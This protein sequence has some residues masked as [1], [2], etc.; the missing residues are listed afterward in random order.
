MEL[1]QGG[2]GDGP[3][4][5]QQRVNVG[6][7]ERRASLAGGAALIL[8]GL[9]NVAR[10]R[11]LPGLTLVLA[12]GLLVYRGQ[13]GHC[14]L[15]QA[16]GI[17]TAGTGE[18]GVQVEKF[19]TID[20]TPLQVYQFWR[21]QENLPRFLRHL[22]S[23]QMTGELSSHWKASGP[24]GTTLEWDAELVEDYPGEL[25]L[26]RSVGDAPLPNEGLVEFREAPGGRGTEVKVTI[27]YFPPGR[28]AARLADTITARQ[29]EA[30]L[31]RLK[32]ILET[33]ATARAEKTSEAA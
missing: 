25:L 11:Y 12:G 20:R 19:L 7:Q 29:I 5:K 32:Q 30:D 26:W 9:R 17:D 8:S 18:N 23:V 2:R 24:A 13:T 31:T 16:A 28:L 4:R 3:G 14:D 6:R 21:N 22:D 15:Y 10:R 27:R 1:T 33:D